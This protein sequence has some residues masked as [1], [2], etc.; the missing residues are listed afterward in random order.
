MRANATA[1]IE[2]AKQHNLMP[3]FWL[4]GQLTMGLVMAREGEAE[5][6]LELMRRSVTERELRSAR[7]PEKP[8]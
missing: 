5:A 8:L 7:R 6:G 1:I 3:Y 4:N 2:L